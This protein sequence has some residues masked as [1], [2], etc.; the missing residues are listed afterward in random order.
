[1]RDVKIIETEDGS[2]SLFVPELNETYHSF[3]GA[4]SESEY[5]FIK[6][7]LHYQLQYQ[8][9][10]TINVLEVGF[11][12]GLNALL[13]LRES[14]EIQNTIEYTSLEPYPLDMS[15]VRELNYHKV[16]KDARLERLFTEIHT[17]CWDEPVPVTAT[18]ILDKQRKKLEDFSAPEELYNLVY[19][20]AFAP[21][22]QA[23]LWMPELLKKVYDMMEPKGVLVTYC[24]KGQFKRDLKEVGFMVETLPGPPG[25][26]EMV[27]AVK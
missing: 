16:L 9:D 4:V 8:P 26:K 2:N 5:V 22:K 25:K 20:D 15:I 6:M 1:M 11:G 17:C 7:G 23:E 19:F 14:L 27:R 12:T 13:T 3:H 18:F 24:A 10:E 21:S